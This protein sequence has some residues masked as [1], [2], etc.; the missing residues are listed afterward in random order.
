LWVPFELGRPLGPP[1]NTV[2]QKRVLTALTKLFEESEGPVLVDFP[3]DE[4]ESS[5]EPTVLACPV[6]YSQT[7][8]EGAETD[9]LEAAFR[10]EISAMRPWY[11]MA[12]AKRKRT[13]VGISGINLDA[14]GD[15]IYASAKGKETENPR[16]DLAPAYTLKYATEDLKAY[17]I[18]GITAQPGQEGASS[19]Q[20]QDWFWDETK[21][22][23]VLLELKQ[24]CE[25]SPDQFMNNIG[26]H[27]LMPGDIA[28][29]KG[30]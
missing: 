3:D 28:R 21:A 11:D 1:N 27:Y 26:H 17:Y 29:R 5:N 20:L 7:I 13:T 4:P 2:F 25:A 6:I 8:A 30:K 9:K 14:L 23:E 16:K 10:R 15:F 22:G 19:Q 24:V 18:E 12:V